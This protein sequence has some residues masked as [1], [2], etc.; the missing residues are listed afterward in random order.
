[1][2]VHEPILA[3]PPLS[4]ELAEHLR[5]MI[6]EGELRSGDKVPEKE[7]TERFGVSRTPL[8]EALKVLASEGYIDLVPNRG[9]RVRPLTREEMEEAFPVLAALEALAGELACR[10]AADAEIED[11]KALNARMR[12]RYDA[13]DLQGYFRLN[14]KIHATILSA[15]RNP[16][17]AHCHAQLA[18]RLRRARYAANMSDERWRWAMREHDEIAEAF[19]ARDACRLGS[20]MKRHFEEKIASMLVALVEEDSR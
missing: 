7:L 10:H 11:V 9:A 2:N 20:V 17:L 5:R 1:M 16:T 13:G 18:D 3:R 19:E 12:E 4:V 8:R 14:Q 15:A 6:V